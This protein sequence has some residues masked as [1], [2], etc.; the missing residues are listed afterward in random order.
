MLLSQIV[1]QYSANLPTGIVLEDWQIMRNL[2]RAVRLYCGYAT[3]ESAPSEAELYTLSFL[4]DGFPEPLFPVGDV[5]SPVDGVDSLPLPAGQDFDLNLSELTII[6]PLWRLYN[7]RE[8]AD[9]LEASRSQGLEVYGRSTAEIEM[10]IRERESQMPYLCF[11]EP[12]VS[13]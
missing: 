2:R 8:N 12:V 3:L 11:V 7:E 6:Q 5:H 9:S 13:I 10:D 4:M 1:E